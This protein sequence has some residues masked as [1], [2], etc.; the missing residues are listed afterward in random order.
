MSPQVSNSWDN[1]TK[2][3]ERCIKSV[4]N[5]T[6][7]NFRVL[8]VCHEKPQIEF[9]HPHIT[10][11]EVEFSV[12][13]LD[14]RSKII[15]KH[16]KMLAGLRHAQEFKPSHTMHVD[17]DECVSKHLAKFVEQ[18]PQSNG[19]FLDKGYVYQEGGKFIYFKRK[20]FYRWCATSNIFRYNL[21]YLP[22][23]LNYNCIDINDC[24]SKNLSEEFVDF[25]RCNLAHRLVV[26]NRAQKGIPIAPLP[27]P[28]AVY[29]LHGESLSS[30]NFNQLL[31]LN[32]RD[33]FTRIKKALF[34]R[35]LSSSICNEFSIY[36]IY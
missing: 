29:V 27:F 5:Q 34:L 4:C 32:S 10:Y 18:N 24:V 30:N 9:T 33:L 6:S 14:F 13:D 17:A 16:C 20:D 8:V 35:S 23:S 31:K 11:V 15:D 28:G 21:N 2:L 1:V 22:E 12:P 36:N 3:F 25:Y 7:A 19:W 26:Q